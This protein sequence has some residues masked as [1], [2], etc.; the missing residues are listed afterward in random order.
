MTVKGIEWTADVVEKVRKDLVRLEPLEFMS[1]MCM[2]FDEYHN[3]HR[4]TDA[5]E[6]AKT[7]GE[8][9]SFVNNANGE[10]LNVA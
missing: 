5:A 3:A 4:D 1:A 9:V 8:L 6:M 7:V 2:L 10:Y